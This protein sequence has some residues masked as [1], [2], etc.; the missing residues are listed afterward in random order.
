MGR[1]KKSNVSSSTGGWNEENDVESDENDLF[2][3]GAFVMEKRNSSARGKAAAVSRIRRNEEA[4]WA[5][6]I[7]EHYVVI[8]LCTT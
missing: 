7:R 6:N 8:P 3:S 1:K 2:G 5:E 4:S